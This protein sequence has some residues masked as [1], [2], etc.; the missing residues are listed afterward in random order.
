MSTQNESV[1]RTR[2]H[3]TQA[4]VER[5][6]SKVSTVS[7]GFIKALSTNDWLLAL[8]MATVTISIGIFLG[9]SNNKIVP[10][11]TEPL[12]HYQA[13]PHNKLNLLSNWDGPNY[14]SI[15]EHG[16]NSSNTNF[17]PLYPIL[18][19]IVHLVI[20][21]PL[22]SAV[23]VA[24]IFFVVAIYFALK[25]FKELFHIDNSLEALRGVLFFILFPT[26]VFLFATY[27][28]SLFAAASLAALY[29]ALK[30]RPILAGLFTLVATATHTNGVFDLALIAI[31]LYEMR[32]PIKK[33]ILGFGIGVLGVLSYMVYL[34]HKFGNPLQFIVDQENNGW[35]HGI[36]HSTPDIG[37]LNGLLLVLIIVTAIYWWWQHYYSFAIYSSLFLLIPLI[38]GQF[39]GFARYTLMIFPAQAMLYSLT[40]RHN[41]AYAL[42]LSVSAVLWATFLFHYSG[43]YV[44]G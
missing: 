36:I 29:F 26:G 39:G 16:Y 35:L 19:A 37:W 40:R 4:L 43:G 28:E 24:W 10:V 21:S 38:G 42:T 22:D 8:F 17:F 1:R 14:I 11:N 13:E 9:A 44:G 34:W 15:A 18:I 27:T 41:T 6:H 23:I 33:I 2:K 3:R 30:R 12:A 25:V 20:S 7:E 31:L 32:V 5:V